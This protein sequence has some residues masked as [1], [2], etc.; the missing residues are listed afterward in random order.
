MHALR[1]LNGRDF[2]LFYCGYSTS[3]LG[4]S[5]AGV[6]LAFAV[7]DD[8]RSASDLGLVL[9]AVPATQLVFMLFGGVLADWLGPRRIMLAGDVI[10]CAAQTAL[11]AAVLVGRPS[12]WVFMALAAVRGLGEALF[13]P[14]LGALVVHVVP[15]ERRGDANVLLGFSQSVAKVA[16]PTLAGVLIA[17]SNAGVVLAADAATYGCSLAALG[18]LRLRD[19]GGRRRPS[20]LRSLAE[21]WSEFTSRPWL[22]ASTVQFIC[23]NFLVWGPFLLLGPVLMH[24]HPSGARGWGLVMSG[25]GAGS[26]LGG[27]VALGRRPSRPLV[28]ATAATIGYAA[29]CAL[30]ALQAPTA[31]IAAGACLAGVGSTVSAALSDTTTQQLTPVSVLARVRTFQ[32]FG[33]FSLGPL[34]FALAGPAATVLGARPV[35]GFGAVAALVSATA[36]LL[37]PSVRAVRRPADDREQG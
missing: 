35:L 24:Q 17:V 28:V 6:A 26:I 5:M 22:V 12:L 15:S 27:L 25:Y 18:L 9:A 2:R 36:V 30:F 10:R 32:T 31:V 29:P 23:V 34:A 37:L 14:A 33:A 11:A 4:S 20:M 7:L 3:L 21:G 8:G 16:G 1:T 19:V 13:N